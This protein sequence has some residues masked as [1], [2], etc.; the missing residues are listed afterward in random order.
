M[1]R[2][3]LNDDKENHAIAK[4]SFKS[5]LKETIENYDTPTLTK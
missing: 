3:I 5:L 4:Y 2:I 1:S